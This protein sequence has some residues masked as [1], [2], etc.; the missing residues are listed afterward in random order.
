MKVISLILSILFLFSCGGG[1][2][3]SDSPKENFKF[4]EKRYLKLAKGTSINDQKELINVASA[5]RALARSLKGLEWSDKCKIEEISY[6]DGTSFK[7]LFSIFTNFNLTSE[8]DQ[9]MYPHWV[10]DC[11]EKK[12][13]KGSF[14]YSI[15]VHEMF[16]SD[17]EIILLSNLSKNKYLNFSANYIASSSINLNEYDF[18]LDLGFSNM[19]YEVSFCIPKSTEEPETESLLSCSEEP[20]FNDEKKITFW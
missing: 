13:G 19:P 18:Y 6:E 17:D 20:I 12:N 1:G 11:S 10:I 16:L 14:R 5:S 2:S 9:E 7:S 4:L 8:Q 3:S 15:K